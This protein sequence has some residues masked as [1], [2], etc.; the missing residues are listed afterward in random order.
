MRSS[1]LAARRQ[2]VTERD[3]GPGGLIAVCDRDRGAGNVR[4][5]CPC[6]GPEDLFRVVDSPHAVDRAPGTRGRLSTGYRRADPRAWRGSASCM[7]RPRHL[8]LAV[9]HHGQG[10]GID[11]GA[12]ALRGRRCKCRPRRCSGLRRMRASREACAAVSR[13]GR[14]LQKPI[15]TRSAP[16]LRA[17]APYNDGCVYSAG[18]VVCPVTVSV[19]LRRRP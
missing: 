9:A 2:V 12:S 8:V 13:P 4:G 16:W 19:R 18:D 3:D 6:L 11:L 17:A 5:L 10:R 7:S 1:S 14:R 15:G